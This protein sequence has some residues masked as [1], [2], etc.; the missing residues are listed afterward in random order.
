MRPKF[1]LIGLYPRNLRFEP[2]TATS[3]PTGCPAGMEFREHIWKRKKIMRLAN[4]TPF[5]GQKPVV[6]FNDFQTSLLIE[7][8]NILHGSVEYSTRGC[9]AK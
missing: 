4:R 2:L 3:V 9:P 5:A 8:N 7:V 6:K 1:L